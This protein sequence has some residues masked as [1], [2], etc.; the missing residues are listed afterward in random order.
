MHGRRR[1]ISIFHPSSIYFS[2]FYL[3]DLTF[4]SVWSIIDFCSLFLPLYSS[5]FCFQSKKVILVSVQG[6]SSIVCNYA[7][8]MH[9]AK[10]IWLNS[11]FFVQ[12]SWQSTQFAEYAW[13]P[14]LFYSL[15]FSIVMLRKWISMK[16][17]T[18]VVASSSEIDLR[19][20]WFLAAGLGF[21]DACI[22][23][24]RERGM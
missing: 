11:G 16:L 8:P 9:G 18:F 5:F 19:K 13:I 14:I 4:N 24:E 22:W 1:F 6:L 3:V 10:R 17:P 23:I 15:R 20:P 7:M 21:F 2:Y 12:L